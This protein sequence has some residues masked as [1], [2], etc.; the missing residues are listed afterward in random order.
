MFHTQKLT[1]DMFLQVHSLPTYRNKDIDVGVDK[2][3]FLSQEKHY[4]FDDKE[5]MLSESIYN[6]IFRLLDGDKQFGSPDDA[7][8]HPF[9]EEK[10]SNE[11]DRETDI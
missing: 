8:A 10:G 11:I 4:T 3:I 7:L 6:L 5:G 2:K 1:S 9:L